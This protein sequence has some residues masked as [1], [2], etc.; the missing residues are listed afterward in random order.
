MSSAFCNP[1]NVMRRFLPT[2]LLP[3]ALS[4]P[5][6]AEGAVKASSRAARRQARQP[7]PSDPERDVPQVMARAKRF[8]GDLI[9]GN[10]AAFV[11]Q[12]AFPFDLEHRKMTQSPA[13]LQHE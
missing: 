11:E 1:P 2:V 5:P 4:L 7:V 6:Q 10:P 13:L 9:D 8:F 3:I 12:T